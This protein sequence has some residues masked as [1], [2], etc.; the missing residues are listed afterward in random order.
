MKDFSVNLDQH[1]GRVTAK[2][3]EHGVYIAVTNLSAQFHY[4]ID[5]H[6]LR[7]VFLTNPHQMIQRSSSVSKLSL[8]WWRAVRSKV[9]GAIER[10]EKQLYGKAQQAYQ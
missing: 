2:W 4:G 9:Y 5:N 10:L 6:A 1:I 3:K 7:Q 8:P